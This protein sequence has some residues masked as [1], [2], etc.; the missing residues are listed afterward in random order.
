MNRWRATYRASLV[1]AAAAMLALAAGPAF[2]VSLEEA[3]R[4]AL[5]TNPGV[6]VVLEDRRAVNQELVQARS[7]YLPTVD[8]R[9]ARGI[10][11]VNNPTSR[12]REGTEVDGHSVQLPR[13]DSSL[14]IR[15]L[16][17]DG[18]D[19]QSQVERQL[20]RVRSA[21]RRVRETSEFTALDAIETYLESTRLREVVALSFENIKVHEEFVE[22]IKVQVEGG[23]A[24]KADLDQAE[25][26]LA[27]ARD[28]LAVTEGELRDAD[29]KYRRVVGEDAIRLRR[30][31]IPDDALPSTVVKAIAFA[32]KF[33]PTIHVARS[34]I[35]IA[36]AEL[37]ATG[38]SFWPNFAIEMAANS[39]RNTG[40]TRGQDTSMSALLVMNYSL[41]RGGGDIARRREFVSRLAEA[42]QR[43]NQTIRGSEETTRLSWSALLSARDRLTQLRAVVQ[44]NE[45]VKD[46]F[47]K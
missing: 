13:T 14:T 39:N 38:A 30:P 19:T 44:A 26:R 34:D 24:G 6:G 10:E 18:F 37:A 3:I 31:I 32:I 20:A 35:D 7:A 2:A 42:R 22:L 1:Y 21:A 27:G 5:K 36:K 15:Q 46:S 28:G 25:G 33:N 16:L 23:A 11:R 40:G 9:V 12:G 4:I 41:Y 29:A 47:K 8:V 17:F 43:L 45:N